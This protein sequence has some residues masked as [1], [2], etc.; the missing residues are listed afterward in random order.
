MVEKQKLVNP[1]HPDIAILLIFVPFISA[2]NYYLTYSGIR[3]S[4][5]LVLTF[6]IDTAQGYLAWWGVRSFIFYLDKKYPY[7]NGFLNRMALQLSGSLVIGLF[8]IS[9]LTEGVSW[10]AK[11][12]PAP[13]NFYTV[14]LFII[15]IWFF[16]INGLYVG[17]RY[18]NLW[19]ASEVVRR[20]EVRAKSGGLMVT[21]GKLDMKL[22]F[23]DVAGLYV[24][25]EY[26]VACST[27][28]KK[29]YLDQSLDQIEKDL[30]TAFFFRLNR[31]YILHR[32]VLAGF[33]R[34]ENGKLIVLSSKP[35]S[36]P[37]EIPVSRLK[38]PA[39]KS[40][41]RPE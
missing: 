18:Y 27:A 34:T 16:V 10:I 21:Q 30:P 3:V 26:V 6:A 11:G 24:D 1:Y 17:L 23:E 13:L 14:D 20:E 19:K 8:I 25:N 41:F 15:S 40:W 9:A 39:F 4:W 28:G 31:Q 32:Q 36:F 12:K 7:E 29:Y 38:A 5:F 2:F 35:E 22:A 37:S 33:R